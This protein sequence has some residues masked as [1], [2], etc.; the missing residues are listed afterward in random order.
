MNRS[1]S[2]RPV[3]V[4]ALVLGATPARAVFDACEGG[5]VVAGVVTAEEVDV[6]IEGRG[7][8]AALGTSVAVGDFNGDGVGD[9]ALAAPT[10]R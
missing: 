5:G 10:R 9:L 7:A 1:C 8:N 2:L 4:A 3:V 6:R